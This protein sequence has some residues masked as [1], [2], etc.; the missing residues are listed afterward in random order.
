MSKSGGKVGI[1]KTMIGDKTTINN[2]SGIPIRIVSNK[3]IENA[4]RYKM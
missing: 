3:A 2:A 4:M 1:N